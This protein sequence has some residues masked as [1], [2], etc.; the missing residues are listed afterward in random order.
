MSKIKFVAP[1]GKV[2]WLGAKAANATSLRQMGFRPYDEVYAP[3]EDV[4]PVKEFRNAPTVQG[5]LDEQ[6]QAEAAATEEEKPK[7][8]RPRKNTM[9]DAD[10]A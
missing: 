5:F 3:V 10:Q 6:E 8:G 2:V 9:S 1:S 7:R 4:Q